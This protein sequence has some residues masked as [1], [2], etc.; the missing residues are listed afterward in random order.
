MRNQETLR[1]VGE[2]GIL[3]YFTLVVPDELLLKILVLQQ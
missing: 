1:E 3:F 2:L